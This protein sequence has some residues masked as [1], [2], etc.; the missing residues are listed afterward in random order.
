MIARAHFGRNVKNR[1]FKSK[2]GAIE[3]FCS[4]MV[5]W[6]HPGSRTNDGEAFIYDTYGTKSILPREIWRLAS[7]WSKN[8]FILFCRKQC[9]SLLP[10]SI[11]LIPLASHRSLAIRK[12]ENFG[13]LVNRWGRVGV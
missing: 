12:A 1:N 7:K 2:Y 11:W 13:F 4:E 9:N 8:I 10:K 5:P 3:N 6:I